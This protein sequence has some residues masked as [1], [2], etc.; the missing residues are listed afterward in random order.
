MNKI[1]E[2]ISQVLGTSVD[3]NSSMENVEA[4]DSF[5]HVMIMIELK[6]EFDF[7]LGQDEFDKFTSI[8]AIV[9]KLGDKT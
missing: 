8:Q 2:I 3:E 9:A 6:S 1:I 4:W 5:N 7:E